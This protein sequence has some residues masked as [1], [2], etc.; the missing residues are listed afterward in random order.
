M[1][2][3][4][5]GSAMG[6]V[7]SHLKDVKYT[8]GDGTKA[9]NI[10]E[11][12]AAEV[13]DLRSEAAKWVINN[14]D[15]LD[16]LVKEKSDEIKRLEEEAL[17]KENYKERLDDILL[18]VM[19]RHV[20]HWDTADNRPT[21]YITLKCISDSY[22]RHDYL[23]FTDLKQ[24]T[25]ICDYLSRIRTEIIQHR[26]MLDRRF[27]N[28]FQSKDW[29]CVLFDEIRY[30]RPSKLDGTG[31]CCYSMSERGE[32]VAHLM[33]NESKVCNL[34]ETGDIEGLEIKLDQY[35]YVLMTGDRFIKNIGEN[36]LY[37]QNLA[38]CM[39]WWD[40]HVRYR[41]QYKVMV[42]YMGIAR[43]TL[44]LNVF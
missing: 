21:Q 29:K 38:D 24:S 19:D 35:E 16:I 3:M 37:M 8:N 5:N 39:S 28:S 30:I 17:A 36:V 12:E 9:V 14:Q 13:V 44:H 40:K 20:K 43:E 4:N 1:E 41:D 6:T 23:I 18:S 7:K 11:I 15:I 27:K 34:T 32:S 42:K 2:S 33:L 26:S 22:H 25:A 31:R 10:G